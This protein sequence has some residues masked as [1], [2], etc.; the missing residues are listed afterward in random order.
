M[1]RETGFEPATLSL[2]TVFTESPDACKDMQAFAIPTDLVSV[3]VQRSR[4]NPLLFEDFAS[5][6]RAPGKAWRRGKLMA[7]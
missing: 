2:G 6:L 3:A 7:N 4:E 5:P 1:E